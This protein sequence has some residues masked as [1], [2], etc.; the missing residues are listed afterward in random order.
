MS[1]GGTKSQSRRPSYMSQA[2]KDESN[3][4]AG[5]TPTTNDT[6][7]SQSKQDTQTPTQLIRE[8]SDDDTDVS[9]G[10]SI[11]I[12][13]V[14]WNV[15]TSSVAGKTRRDTITA[16]HRD[17][18]EVRLER[19]ATALDQ[20]FTVEELE[21]AMTRATIRVEDEAPFRNSQAIAAY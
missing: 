18:P 7:D 12:Q 19:Q 5:S 13:W 14:G 9:N 6:E 8:N 10:Q 17:V 16:G 4:I 20:P 1:P 15:L 3:T 21:Q 2:S 11:H